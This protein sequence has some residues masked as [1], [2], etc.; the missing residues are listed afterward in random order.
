M[1]ERLVL[2][3]VHPRLAVPEHGST[4]IIP[5]PGSC[6]V[7]GALAVPIQPL[8]ERRNPVGIEHPFKQDDALVV[9]AVDIRLFD[10]SGQL[11]IHVFKL[12]AYALRG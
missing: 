8:P 6:P 1:D 12:I 3:N 4:L 2:G 5:V 11:V 10:A 7:G 9:I